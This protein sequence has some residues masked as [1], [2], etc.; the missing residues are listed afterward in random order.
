MASPRAPGWH[1]LRRRVARM[2][3]SDQGQP[4]ETDPAPH[5]RSRS[6]RVCDPDL[7]DQVSA[8]AVG[9]RH[10]VDDASRGVPASFRVAL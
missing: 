1:T 3:R 8:D 5:S 9:R 4:R 10:D 2:A 6:V 7:P